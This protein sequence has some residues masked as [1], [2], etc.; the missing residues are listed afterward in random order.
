MTVTIKEMDIAHK[1]EEALDYA[2]D[3]ECN[4]SSLYLRCIMI[5]R[6]EVPYDEGG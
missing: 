3:R 5:K 4:F 2:G 6:L 1:Y